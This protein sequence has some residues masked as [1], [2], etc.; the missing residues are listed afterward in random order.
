MFIFQKTRCVSIFFLS[1]FFSCLFAVFIYSVDIVFTLDQP[2]KRFQHLSTVVHFFYIYYILLFTYLLDNLLFC[3]YLYAQTF[4][5]P[6][7]LL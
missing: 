5:M 6:I 2:A 3:I 7:Y 1:F 4:F